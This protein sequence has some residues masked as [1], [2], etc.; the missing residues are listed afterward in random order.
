[1]ETDLSALGMNNKGEVRT[2]SEFKSIFED[3]GQSFRPYRCPFCEVPY[4][5]RCIITECVKAPHFKLPD[6]TR[7][8]GDCNGEV[9]EDEVIHRDIDLA[10]P[11]RTVVGKI[12][13]PEALVRPRKA[14]IVRRVGDDGFG[15]PP[16]AVEVL[17][18]RKIIAADK[19]IS[20]C[21]TA[22]QLRP[23]VHAHKQLRK[24]AYKQAIAAKLKPGTAEY[25]AHFGQTLGEHSLS[26]Y[27]QKLTYRNAFQGHKL[28]PHRAERLYFGNG[29][30]T[31]E[32][33]YLVLR[34]AQSW[35]TQPKSQ[36]NLLPFFVRISRT[37]D[38]NPS[39]SHLKAMEELEQ[40]A[41][42]SSE[43]EWYAYGLPVIQGDR[44]ELAVESLDQIYW[45]GQHKR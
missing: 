1:M 7:H 15:L 34:D 28:Q 29:K 19:T 11:K 27:G 45:V 16:D 44:Y 13:V 17:R 40:L 10:Q 24:H 12:D 39:T 32:G 25:N 38:I 21:F 2:A 18:R 23:I 3:S 31:A 6:S 41:A 5:D 8:R 14:S 33:G 20:K 26:L 22:S 4:E 42:S 36:L 37:V 43:L 9:G 35:P 30:V